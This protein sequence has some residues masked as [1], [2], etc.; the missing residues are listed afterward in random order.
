MNTGGGRTSHRKSSSHPP[1]LI[2]TSISCFP[3]TPSN[4]TLTTIIF[5]RL[6]FCLG[7]SGGHLMHSSLMLLEFYCSVDF[8][9]PT[10]NTI[11]E[12]QIYF[13][14]KITSP[15]VRRMRLILSPQLTQ[16]RAGTEQQWSLRQGSSEM[17]QYDCPVCCLE[18]IP[19]LRHREGRWVRADD[20]YK[21]RHRKSLGSLGLLVVIR[22]SP[23]E[24]KAVCTTPSFNPCSQMQGC[25]HEWTNYLRLGRASPKRN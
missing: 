7:L 18:N 25:L 1:Y 16:G 14:L 4:S 17:S 12:T 24:K 10:K 19:R 13:Y 11:N 3:N 21:V 15:G 9:A 23:R 6:T 22:Q 20:L 2:K 5:V 8:H